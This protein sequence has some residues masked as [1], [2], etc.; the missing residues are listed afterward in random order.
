MIGLAGVALLMFALVGDGS[1]VLAGV[2]DTSDVAQVAARTAARAVNPATG[3]LD[4]VRATAAAH[5]ELDDAGVSGR[6]TVSPTVVTVTATDTID[7]A[8]LSM[9]GIRRHTVTAT[10]T[11]QLLDRSGTP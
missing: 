7:L 6:V 5:Q 4:V 2:S 1:R 10:R 3:K 11:S 8:L 9:V